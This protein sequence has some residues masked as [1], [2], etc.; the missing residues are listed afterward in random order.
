LAFAAAVAPAGS[1]VAVALD[2]AG[3]NTVRCA[4]FS[5]GGFAGRQK[6]HAPAAMSRHNKIQSHERKR[7]E[8]TSNHYL[9]PIQTANCYLPFSSLMGAA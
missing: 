1:F 5:A 3:A 4:A 6:N 9:I 7:I 8:K 2:L